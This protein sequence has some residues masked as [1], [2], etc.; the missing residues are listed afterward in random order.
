MPKK[1]DGRSTRLNMFSG[2]WLQI[3]YPVTSSAQGQP[4]VVLSG[5][6]SLGRFAY[7]NW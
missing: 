3:L 2:L 1:D 5:R 6:Q 4:Q 7:D